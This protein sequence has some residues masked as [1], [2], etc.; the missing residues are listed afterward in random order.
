M[1]YKTKSG[2]IVAGMLEAAA[3]VAGSHR[4]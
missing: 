3:L 2:Y 4:L 1:E